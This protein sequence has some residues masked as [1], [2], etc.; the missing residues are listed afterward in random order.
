MPG[1]RAESSSADLTRR[2]RSC[3]YAAAAEDQF[4]HPIAKAII[5]AFETLEEPLPPIDDSQVP[6]R[7]R[8]HGPS[9]EGQTVRVGSGRFMEL[10][11]IA[12]PAKRFKPHSTKRTDEGHTLVMVGIDDA[13]GG[14]IE[15]QASLRPEVEIDN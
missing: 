10:E 1:G 6:G 3:A 9:I 2:G 8:H 7:L 15:L 14:A 5:H 12:I 13:L 11:G 4:A